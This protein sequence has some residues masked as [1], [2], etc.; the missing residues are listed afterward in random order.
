MMTVRPIR[1]KRWF[2]LVPRE[3]SADA[4]RHLRPRPSLMRQVRP[5]G[6]AYCVASLTLT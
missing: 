3:N 2:M 4:T 5:N 6:Q 1:S